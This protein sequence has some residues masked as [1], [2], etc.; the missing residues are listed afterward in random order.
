MAVQQAIMRAIAPKTAEREG[1]AWS[2]EERLRFRRSNLRTEAVA[3]VPAMSGVL[4]LSCREGER[5]NWEAFREDAF[6]QRMGRPPWFCVWPGAGVAAF[7]LPPVRV[8]VV[9]FQCAEVWIDP[10]GH[11]G[12]GFDLEWRTELGFEE[13]LGDR[14]LPGRHPIDLA[15]SPMGPQTCVC[16]GD[17]DGAAPMTFPRCHQIWVVVDWVGGRDVSVIGC[18]YLLGRDAPLEHRWGCVSGANDEAVNR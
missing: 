17:G 8:A 13:G 6:R 18:E 15:G 12:Q 3:R 7:G 2:G 16:H 11:S 5:P 10:D 4:L 9:R 1:D 14:R